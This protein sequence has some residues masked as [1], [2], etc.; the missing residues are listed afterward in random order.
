MVS[1]MISNATVM[2]SETILEKGINTL[3][4]R[5]YYATREAL[6]YEAVMLFLTHRPEQRLEM[7]IQLYQD[8]IV[9]LSRAAELAGLHFW[10]FEAILRARQINIL[11]PD[12]T[13]AQIQRGV[14]LIL[15]A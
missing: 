6:L 8:E 15:G 4:Q 14:N 1:P 12:Q 13:S 2:D 11:M 5:G 3:V 7:A 9:T 10:D